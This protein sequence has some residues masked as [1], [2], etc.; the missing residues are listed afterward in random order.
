VLPRIV[1]ILADS[2]EMVQQ[3]AMDAVNSFAAQ[4]QWCCGEGYMD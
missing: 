4:G 2:S 1:G 3:R